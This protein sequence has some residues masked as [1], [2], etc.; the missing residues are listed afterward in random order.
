MEARATT[1]APV[2][3]AADTIAIGVF[4]GEDV[5]HDVDDGALQALVDSGEAQARAAQGRRHPRRRVGAGCWSGW[6]RATSSTPERARVAAAVALGRA[7][8]LGAR[9]LCWELPHHMS[10]EQ[11]AALRRGHGAG[12]LRVPRVQVLRR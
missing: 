7:R 6:G 8:E 10:G 11:A 1:D 5:A 4:E 12:R 2:D 3:T 9:S